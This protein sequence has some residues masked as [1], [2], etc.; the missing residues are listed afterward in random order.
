MTRKKTDQEK[1]QAL[2]EAINESD[3]EEVMERFNQECDH[4]HGITSV[5]HGFDID[6][7]RHDDMICDECGHTWVSWL[8]PG[9]NPYPVFRGNDGPE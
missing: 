3:I 2:L 4:Q 9:D 7:W 5:D 6:G 1:A 8:A